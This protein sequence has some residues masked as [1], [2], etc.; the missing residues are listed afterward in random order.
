MIDMIQYEYTSNGLR[1][2]DDLAAYWSKIIRNVARK[3]GLVTIINHA[4]VTGADP[5]RVAALETVLKLAL[6]LGFDILPGEEA[7]L[8]TE[9]LT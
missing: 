8:R 1:N 3:N 6:D 7:M 4:H 9:H 5:K 2:P